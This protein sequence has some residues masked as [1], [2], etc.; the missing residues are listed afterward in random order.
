[1]KE[2]ARIKDELSEEN[3][4]KEIIE[5]IWKYFFWKNYSYRK[6]KKSKLKRFIK[7]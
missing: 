2:K 6:T 5:K 7:L 1:M 3:L 4:Q